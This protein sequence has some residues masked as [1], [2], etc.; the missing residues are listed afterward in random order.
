MENNDPIYLDQ[1]F[2]F[3]IRLQIES[4]LDSCQQTTLQSAINTLATEFNGEGLTARQAV[5]HLMEATCLLPGVFNVQM[6][7]WRQRLQELVHVPASLSGYSSL[8]YMLK[9]SADMVDN[10]P[11]KTTVATQTA[12]SNPNMDRITEFVRT[13]Y[14]LAWILESTDSKN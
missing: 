8:N 14:R 3:A 12:L 13:K 5:I 4:E 10:K 7:S 9:L 1:L 11:V 2:K 6:L